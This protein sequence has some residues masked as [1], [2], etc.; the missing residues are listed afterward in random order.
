MGSWG[1][2][3]P[4]AG[5]KPK[6]LLERIEDGSFS[7]DRHTH[8]LETD[9]SLLEVE[10]AVDDPRREQFARLIDLQLLFRSVP[11]GYEVSRRGVL[12]KIREELDR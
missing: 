3:R 5:R 11:R 8:L 12:R 9:D 2:S 1:G 7:T 10:L 6:T 4:G